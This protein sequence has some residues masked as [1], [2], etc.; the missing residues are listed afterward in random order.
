VESID[1]HQWVIAAF[2]ADRD[3]V[4]D[5]GVAWLKVDAHRNHRGPYTAA[6]ALLRKLVPC[7]SVSHPSLV[8]AHQLTLLSVSPEVRSCLPVPDEVVKWLAV[9]RE[10]D[11][12]SWILRLSHGIADF[13]LSYL[14]YYLTHARISRFG[15]AFENAHMADPVDREFMAVLLRRADPAQLA[16]RI[17]SSC[18][19]LDDPLR[20]VLES[21][22]VRTDVR[23]VRPDLT[24]EIPAAVR[25]LPLADLR[26]IANDY[27]ESNCTSDRLFAKH[28]Y[29]ALP[30]EERKALHLARASALE[31]LN[32]DSLKLGAIPFHHEHASAGT[33]SLLAA[34]DRCMALAY[35]DAALNLA[36]RGRRLVGSHRGETHSAFSR[37]ILFS[38]LLLGRFEE[39]EAACAENLALS[40]DPALLARTAYAKAILNARLYHAARRD[41]PAARVW[42]GKALS[43]MESLPASETNAAH[44]AFLKNTL[45][46]VEMR[47]GRPEVAHQLLSDSLD[48]LAKEAPDGHDAERTILLHNRARLQVAMHRPAE[49]IAD[50]TRLLQQQPGDSSAYFDR[51]VLHQRLGRYEDALRD[52]DAAIQWSPP[53]P[54]SYLNRARC[55]V[56]LGRQDDALADF[57]RVLVLS[58]SHSGALFDRARLRFNQGHLDAART[59]AETGLR[60]S[61]ANA[62]LLC[63]YGLLDLK[64]KRLDR[65]YESFTKAIQA[66]PSSADAW[67]NRATVLFRQGEL[68]SA[69]ADLTHALGLGESA[70][71]FY[72]RGR[73]FEAQG[74]WTEAIQDY[75]RALGLAGGEAGHIRYHLELCRRAVRQPVLY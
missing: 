70:D 58:P 5:G 68:D 35:Y 24:A 73:I 39:T 4:R 44:I 25:R 53:Y 59:D 27:V 3:A 14:P 69:I 1:R 43:L 55:L 54:A 15:V 33:A 48:Y 74:K 37:N 62:R 2:R 11:P 18:E 60:F 30:D 29:A 63:L 49:A 57:D 12:P 19:L 31:A 51:A 20:S 22:A 7:A 9:S 38:L 17:C 72:N 67:A 41:Y 56:T 21:H 28:A 65:A 61:P 66:E 64:D 8:A 10:G 6:G 42:A 52:Y 40:D 13:L 23:P 75:S 34:S 26:V 16:I 36:L 47:I 50:L 32:E 46:L 71:A 45:A